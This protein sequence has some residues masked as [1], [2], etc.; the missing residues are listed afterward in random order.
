MGRSLN[1]SDK[2]SINNFL[3]SRKLCQKHSLYVRSLNS[4]RHWPKASQ[5]DSTY[6]SNSVYNVTTSTKSDQNCRAN[7]FWHQ[8][9]LFIFQ[10]IDQTQ[11]NLQK[12]AKPV[13]FAI[14]ESTTQR[15]VELALVG[16]NWIITD[17]ENRYQKETEWKDIWFFIYNKAILVNTKK[18]HCCNPKAAPDKQKL[19]DRNGRSATTS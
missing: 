12:S 3:F 17:Q 11:M 1:S 13:T 10:F 18:D 2:V 6:C 7:R 4:T 14:S 15:Q 9:K 8:T 19:C 16:R 5:C